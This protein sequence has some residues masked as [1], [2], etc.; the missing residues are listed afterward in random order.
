M[1]SIG[2]LT[3]H[4]SHNFGSVFQA[5]GL[6]S[7][8]LAHNYE[9][10]ILNFRPYSQIDKYSALPLRYGAKT[11]LRSAAALP[12]LPYTRTTAKKYEQFIHDHLTDEDPIHLPEK[13]PNAVK[14]YDICLSGSDQIWGYSIPEFVR[15]PADLRPAYYFDF[16]DK[17]KISYASSFGTATIEQLQPYAQYLQQYFALSVREKSS[18]PIAEELSGKEVACCLD[19]TFLLDYST[20]D[21]LSQTGRINLPSTT[22]EYALLYSLQGYSSF[23]SLANAVQELKDLTGLPVVFV[24]HFANISV[25]GTIPVKG[26]GPL[27]ILALFRNASYILTDTF[28]GTCFSMHFDKQFSIYRPQD[29]DPR[30]V[31]VTTRM[32][33]EKRYC[34]DIDQLR[35]SLEEEIDYSVVSALRAMERDQSIQYLLSALEE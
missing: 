5:Y 26:T 4:A 9:C 29:R 3:F 18:V 28:H 6:K 20:L 33:L 13:L 7:F 30:L 15:S 32:G 17:K 31:D 8:L 27:D 25:P 24:N 11:F 35:A 22:N 16:T 1:T 10:E 19:P 34:C 23:S 21:N 2:L 12:F 14:P